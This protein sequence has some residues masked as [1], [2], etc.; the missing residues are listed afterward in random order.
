[1]VVGAQ[2]NNLMKIIRFE[3]RKG[4]IVHGMQSPDGSAFNCEL[5]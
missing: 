1:M 5:D 2:E 4:N 3:D